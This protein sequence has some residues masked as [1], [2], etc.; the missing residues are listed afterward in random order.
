MN[1]EVGIVGLSVMVHN[2]ALK[3]DRNGFPVAGYD[4]EKTT[5]SMI[6]LA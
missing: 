4:L 6:Y 3:M 5:M 2:L 1:Y